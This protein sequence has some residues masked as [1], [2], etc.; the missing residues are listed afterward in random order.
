MSSG[1]DLASIQSVRVNRKGTGVRKATMRKAVKLF[2]SIRKLNNKISVYRATDPRHEVC[3]MLPH[4]IRALGSL[5]QRIDK[6]NVKLRADTA[7]LAEL[8]ASL[9]SA[10]QAVL[11]YYERFAIQWMDYTNFGRTN[12]KAFVDDTNAY[13]SDAKRDEVVCSV[14]DCRFVT[15]WKSLF[16][17]LPVDIFNMLMVYIGLP[18]T[19]KK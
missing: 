4:Q 17:A 1:S 5:T 16:G 7:K 2:R 12:P 15:G 3:G 8:R 10:E 18:L 6:A 13:P 11:P 14:I 9:R 19:A